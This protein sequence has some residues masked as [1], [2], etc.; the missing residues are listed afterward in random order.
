MFDAETMSQLSALAQVIGIDI[1]LAGDN[2][3]VVGMAAAGLPRELRA[4]AIMI[5]I[6]AAML[7]R[8]GFALITAQLMTI[9]GLMAAGGVLLL[10]VAWKLWRELRESHAEQE[11]V[12]AVYGE[13][14]ELIDGPP[15]GEKSLRQAVIQ[16]LLADLTMSLDNV[17]AVA[18]AAHEHPWIMAFGLA[19]SIALMGLAATWIA[20]LL[21]RHRWIAYFG[22]GLI[23]YVALR[24]IWDGG[25]AVVNYI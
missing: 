21:E 16:I 24:M 23:I 5:G 1:V 14:G 6:I 22:L 2:A 11:A 25:G 15:G 13:D 10:W 7:M 19:L 18:G 12:E 20:R 4:R 3:V 9:V 17:L 8:V